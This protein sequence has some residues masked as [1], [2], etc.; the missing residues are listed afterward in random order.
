VFTPFW[1]RVQRLG[2]PPK[3]LP[4]PK[5]LTGVS[6]ITGDPLESHAVE[7]ASQASNS[8]GISEPDRRSQGRPR[9][10]ARS[11]CQDTDACGP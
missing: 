11:L 2:D 7:L 1:R 9:A 10:R 8:A 5:H 6:G 4:A 3:P